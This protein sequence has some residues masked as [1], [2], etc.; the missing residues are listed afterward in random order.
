[1]IKYDT[2]EI[3]N[4]ITKLFDRISTINSIENFEFINTS[5]LYEIA[6][7]IAVK[8]KRRLIQ[9]YPDILDSNQ[10]GEHVLITSLSRL[11][12]ISS[13]LVWTPTKVV[14]PW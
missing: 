7:D 2:N 10:I 6:K 12:T 5:S 1:M 4:D 13:S 11:R 9:K 8:H 3:S 14:V